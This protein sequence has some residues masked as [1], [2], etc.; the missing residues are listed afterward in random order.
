MYLLEYRDSSIK[1]MYHGEFSLPGNLY[2]IGTMNSADRSIKNIDLA[3]RRR[4]DFFEVAP[5]VSVLRGHYKQRRNDLGEKLFD[6]FERLNAQIAS[7]MLDRHHGIG[8][9]YFMKTEMTVQ[10]L[11]SIWELQIAP[12]IEDYLFDR[13]NP[14]DGYSFDSFWS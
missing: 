14:L 12:L 10:A 4:F 8:H 13:A 2:V 7:D 11:R 9:S 1:L 6:G 5:D 3:L